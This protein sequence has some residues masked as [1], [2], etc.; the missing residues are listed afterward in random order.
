MNVRPFYPLMQPNPNPAVRNARPR[1][2]CVTL[3]MPQT[4]TC[5]G[6][7]A[8]LACLKNQ[9]LRNDFVHHAFWLL[10]TF[11]LACVLGV[12]SAA[13]YD[14][15]LRNGLIFDGSGTEPFTGDLAIS[16]QN[17]V[18]VGKLDDGHGRTE[19]DA[20]SLAVAP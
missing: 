20:R 12:A 14:V 4:T 3:Y 9:I 8:F 15:L 7:S 5:R 6:A 1:F 19:I 16:G 13:E 2:R 10:T 11:M 17:I 18:A